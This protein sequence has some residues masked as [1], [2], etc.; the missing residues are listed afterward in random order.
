[1]LS[2]SMKKYVLNR[3]KSGYNKETQNVYNNRLRTYAI[4]AIKDLTLLASKLPEAQQTQIFN[5]ET[6]GPFLRVLFSFSGDNRQERMEDVCRRMNSEDSE[7]KRSRILKLCYEAMNEIGWD[8]N[9]HYF[10]PYEMNILLNAGMSEGLPAFT[11]MRAIYLKGISLSQAKPKD[12]HLQS[13]KR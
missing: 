1:L 8:M 9:G 7:A 4:Q 5:D 10:A 13:G 6:V 3:E 2:R 11:G 12:S